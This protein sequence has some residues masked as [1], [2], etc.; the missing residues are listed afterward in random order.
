MF[1]RSDSFLGGKLDPFYFVD[2]VPGDQFTVLISG[3]E[4]VVLY[5]LNVE[6]SIHYVRIVENVF[7]WIG[8]I[9]GIPNLLYICFKLL[10]V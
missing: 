9:A 7:D 4:L 3:P 6:E 1:N 5:S 8:K 2:Y 10:T